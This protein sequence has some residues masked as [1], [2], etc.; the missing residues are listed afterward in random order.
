M[1]NITGNKLLILNEKD[2]A[3]PVNKIAVDNPFHV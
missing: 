2:A 3:K 1:N